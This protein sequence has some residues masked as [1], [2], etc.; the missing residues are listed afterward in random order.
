MRLLA[1][2]GTISNGDEVKANFNTG[3]ATILANKTWQAT[4]LEPL[5][6]WESWTIGTTNV[7][8]NALS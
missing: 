2:T 1:R 3:V 7:S 4:G 5:P 6:Q 8:S